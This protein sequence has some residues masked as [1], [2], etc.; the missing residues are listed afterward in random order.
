[1]TRG[2]HGPGGA[3]GGG[4][5]CGGPSGV[6][7][8]H[9][10]PTLVVRGGHVVV[11]LSFGVMMMNGGMMFVVELVEVVEVVELAGALTITVSMSHRVTVIGGS[12]IVV[13]EPETVRV[14]RG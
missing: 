1:M 2:G 4:G 8:C 12:V 5:G 10:G 14:M 9:V 13:V 6:I 7:V 11:V 3:G